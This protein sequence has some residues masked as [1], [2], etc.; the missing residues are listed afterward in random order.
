MKA[1]IRGDKGGSK[2]AEDPERSETGAK[3]EKGMK[4]FEILTWKENR[5]SPLEPEVDGLRG[6]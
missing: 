1:R 3:A 6:R 2:R 5:R 4:C